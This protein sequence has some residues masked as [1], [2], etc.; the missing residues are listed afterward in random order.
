MRAADMGPFKRITSGL[1]TR[2]IVVLIGSLAAILLWAKPAVA[3]KPGILFNTVEIGEDGFN[4]SAY[5]GG[6]AFEKLHGITVT[7]LFPEKNNPSDATYAAIM[8][9][10]I[11]DDK[12]DLIVGIGFSVA[13]AISQLA[14]E[15]PRLHFVQ[16]DSVADKPNV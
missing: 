16:I 10:A 15:F 1:A 7:M 2:M 5:N 12:L 14:D 11:I 13:P 4:R 6:K 9:K 3:L 8:R